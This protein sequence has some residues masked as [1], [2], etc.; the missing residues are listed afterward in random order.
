MA[1]EERIRNEFK[2]KKRLSMHNDMLQWRLQNKDSPMPGSPHT[3]VVNGNHN[4]NSRKSLPGG[5]TG[6]DSDSDIIQSSPRS[7]KEIFLLHSPHS[8]LRLIS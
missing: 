1:L 2:E 3:P 8:H 7:V 4:H 5:R 6:Y